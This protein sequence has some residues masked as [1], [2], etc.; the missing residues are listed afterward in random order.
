MGW[1]HKTIVIE[2]KGFVRRGVV[3][4]SDV[5]GRIRR[6]ADRGYQLVSAIPISDGNGGTARI[7]LFLKRETADA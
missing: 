7:A 3:D 1:E 2:T 4:A 5:D 6:W